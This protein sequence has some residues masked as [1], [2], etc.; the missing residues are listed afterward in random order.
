ALALVALVLG[1]LLI[2]AVAFRG[3]KVLSLTDPNSPWRLRGGNFRSAIAMTADRPWHGVG[4][5][6][7][8]EHYPQYRQTGDNETRH[9]H[10]LPLE[11]MAETG[12]PAGAL[13]GGA[14]LFL[15]CAPLVAGA[16]TRRDPAHGEAGDAERERD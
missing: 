11:M 3:G 15:F 4:P 16:R 2:A 12:W 5:G 6:A 14:F 8:G 10:N 7:F 9:V 13:L 1:A